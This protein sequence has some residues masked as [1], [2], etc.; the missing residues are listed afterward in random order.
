MGRCRLIVD[1]VGGPVVRALEDRSGIATARQLKRSIVAVVWMGSKTWRNES[2][3]QAVKGCI[4]WG[5]VC[6]L[7][8]VVC[9]FSPVVVRVPACTVCGLLRIGG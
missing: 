1:V 4:L 3:T 8:S 7:Y 2:P 9:T 5:D 6:N